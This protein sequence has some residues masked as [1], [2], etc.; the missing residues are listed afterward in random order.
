MKKNKNKQKPLDNI[1]DITT[2][3]ILWSFFSQMIFTLLKRILIKA[4]YGTMI[5]AILAFTYLLILAVKYL[6]IKNRIINGK[7]II[8]CIV[9]AILYLLSFLN[10]PPY[11][12]ISLY[13]PWTLYC[14]TLS[15][16]AYSITDYDMLY[17][18]FVKN[19]ILIALLS[20]LIIFADRST[21]AYYMHYSYILSLILF[22]HTAEFIKYKKNK[23]LILLIIELFLIII[24]G[25]WGSILC[26]AFFLFLFILI[27]NNKKHVKA[28]FSLI[29][30]L[31][32][33]NI[34]N[35]LNLIQKTANHF[36]IKSRTLSLL[37]E[38][39]THT[40]GRDVIANDAI[41]LIGNHPAIGVG[42][43]GEFKYMDDYPHNIILDIYLHWGVILG[44]I[45]LV[46]LSYIIIDALIKSRDTGRILLIIFICYG[47]VMLFFSGTYISCDG[48]FIMLGFVFRIRRD[49]KTNLA[50]IR[51]K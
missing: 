32:S 43:A 45:I 48:F 17:E 7:F 36:N 50:K 40:S 18:K 14:I 11:E 37:A 33:A 19:G 13:F 8:A 21:F 30:L 4:P 44:T 34:E 38:N 27:G 15:F 3:I 49:N 51:G 22:F 42:I 24:Y 20:G 29:I 23:Y 25:F 9:V 35:I 39:A 6:I 16:L 46:Y 47:L 5:S 12:A 10:G 26:F 2:S 28:I 1:Q 31:I 41:S